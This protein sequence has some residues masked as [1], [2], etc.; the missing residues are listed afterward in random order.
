MWK[1]IAPKTDVENMKSHCE[2]GP[3][4]VYKGRLFVSA[5]NCIEAVSDP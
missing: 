1:A 4:G 5:L 3:R 2:S